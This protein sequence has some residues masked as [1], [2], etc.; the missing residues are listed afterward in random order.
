MERT[1]YS[2]IL[3]SSFRL[4]REAV[5]ALIE[6]GPTFQ[7]VAEADD[8]GH[9]LRAVADHRPDLIL[10]D[11]DPDYVGSLET[12]RQVIRSRPSTP[13]VALSLHTEDR[14][15]Q[16]ALRTGIRGFV[17]KEGPSGELAV[18]LKL[19]AE[20]E[21]YLSPRIAARVME[22]VRSR[23]LASTPIPELMDLNAREIEILTL[24]SDG[25]TNKEVASTLDLAVDTVR[26]Y[27]KTLMKKL[28]VHNVAGLVQ[29]AASV[30]LINTGKTE[31]G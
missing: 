16:S 14:I 15:I 9:T 26:T 11:L 6:G 12:I 24:L 8:R 13:V 30:G 27:R 23:Q 22:W 2:V 29:I 25:R 19:V 10:F 28:N 4:V 18:V 20:G 31:P 3:V 21:A 7:V 1:V 17:C 5:R